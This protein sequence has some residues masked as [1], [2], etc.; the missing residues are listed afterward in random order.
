M[1]F[2]SLLQHLFAVLLL[3]IVPI[4]E[5]RYDRRL[6]QFTSSHRRT[7]WYQI[8]IITLCVLAVSA[9]ALAYPVNIFT[10]ANRPSVALWLG[11]H[12][13]A[14]FGA[15]GVAV[16]YTIIA[17]GQG[18][19]VAM[20]QALRMR[21]AKAMR[22]LRFVLPVTPRERHWWILVSLSAGVCEEILYRGFVTHYFSGSLSATISLG[23]VG[24]W[25][26][27]SLFF[28]LAHAYQGVAGIVR[29]T[30]AG[31]ILGSI[32]ILSGGLLLP[33]VLHFLFDV[34]ML[35]MYRPMTDEPDTAAQLIKGCE[36]SLL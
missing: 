20:D 6:K 29:T 8:N 31:L 18:F 30:A 14:L 13:T 4:V 35:W 19:Q 36:P 27:A 2:A 28:G 25:L 17:L 22:S 7:A 16:A 23:T 26:T 21:V 33:I 5:V 15:S 32:A 10:L 24:A 1:H 9:L 11:A 3:V 12:P 34:Q